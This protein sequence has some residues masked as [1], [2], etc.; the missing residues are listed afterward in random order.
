MSSGVLIGLEMFLVLGLVLA[1]GFFELRSL[2]RE[3]RR[4]QER[5]AEDDESA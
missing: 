5:K 1:F 4:D 3:R 2:R